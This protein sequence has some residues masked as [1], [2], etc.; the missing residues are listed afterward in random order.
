VRLFV[1]ALKPRGLWHHPRARP[2]RAAAA[3]EAA[4]VRQSRE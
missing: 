1:L 4:P 3:G 2:D